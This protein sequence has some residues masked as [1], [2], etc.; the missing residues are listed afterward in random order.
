[1][2]R[3]YAVLDRLF[4]DYWHGSDKR[5][6]VSGRRSRQQQSAYGERK[7]CPRVADSS[8]PLHRDPC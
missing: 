1:M 5:S 6:A 2:D 7:P 4:E 3:I 8:E